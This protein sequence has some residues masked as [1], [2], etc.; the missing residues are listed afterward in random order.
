MKTCAPFSTHASYL[1]TKADPMAV[2][3]MLSCIIHQEPMTQVDD[4]TCGTVELVIAEALNNIVEHAYSGQTG[5]IEIDV[6]LEND[7]LKFTIVDDG[8]PMPG[9]SLPPGHRVTLDIEE[10]LPEGGFGWYLI[11]TLTQDLQYSRTQN[12]NF[13]RF[14]MPLYAK[15]S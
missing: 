10:D 7:G 11:R 6:K 8:L 12:R 4:D 1:I 15:A 3:N 5:D 9:N 13:L 2:R 14:R